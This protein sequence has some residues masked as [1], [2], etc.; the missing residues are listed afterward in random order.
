V[1]LASNR[2]P[3]T[4]ERRGDGF[5][6]RRGAGGLAGALDPVARE[7]GER[8]VWICAANSE[9]DRAAVRAGE[10]L[11]LAGELGYA[12]DMLDLDPITYTR[13]Y[14]VVSNR[15]LWFAHHCLLDELGIEGFGHDEVSAFE[16]AYEPVNR[17]FARAAAEHSRGEGLVLFQDYH[18]S[19]APAHLRR[20]ASVAVVGHFTH[21]PFATP[22][23]LERLPGP[24]P[25]LI[26]Q[27][28]LA[29]DL[30]GFHTEPWAANL[31]ACCEAL[32]GRFDPAR[33]VAEL[34]ERRAWVR[35]Y[36][37]PIDAQGLAERAAGAAA[38][39]WAE[40]FAG[41]PGR[42]VVRADRTEPSKNIVRGFEAFGLLLD[43]RPELRGEVRFIACV[44]PSRQSLPEYRD[45]TTR[46]ENAVAAV[47]ARHPHAIEL[48]LKD[49]YDRTLG[50][51]TVYDVL[52]VNPLMDGMNLVSKEGPAVNRRDGVLVL[53]RGAGSYG[54]L[55]EHAVTIDDARDVEETAEALGHA[56]DLAA[57]ERARR[58]AALRAVVTGRS[59]QDWICA[60]LDDLEAIRAGGG[61]D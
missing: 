56:L 47:N 54:E 13:Y 12:L 22:A 32:G 24:L 49:D 21:T 15:M 42:L 28:L 59:P 50:A 10:H 11:R 1:V 20:S 52:L 46:I 58:A 35:T 18:L 29:A 4:F 27:G 2:G 3:V 48:Y 51:L 25:S 30:I 61:L 14:D 57:P 6:I 45:Y 16:Q 40:R 53:S 9:A 31:G 36:P 60:Q 17:R 5:A 23:V 19:T 8:A 41:Q 33:G 7:L 26:V 38:E 39:R 44:Y 37:I 43:R 55:G 34:G